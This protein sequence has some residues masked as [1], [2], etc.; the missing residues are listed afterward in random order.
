M[1]ALYN[2]VCCKYND[3]EFLAA[4]IKGSVCADESLI[5]VVT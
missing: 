1:M 3:G 5:D 2:V 4:L